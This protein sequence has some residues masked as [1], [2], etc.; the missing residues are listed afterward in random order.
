MHVQNHEDTYLQGSV[1]QVNGN[2]FMF[3]I[4]L[5]FQDHMSGIKKQHLNS[6]ISS[7][8]YPAYFLI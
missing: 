5:V 4:L 2:H 8:S 1:K 7:L 3:L 6:L